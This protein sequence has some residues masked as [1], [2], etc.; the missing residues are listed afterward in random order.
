V[1]N[2][3]LS[4][5][6]PKTK[7]KSLSQKTSF[8]DLAGKACTASSMGYNAVRRS[9]AN[10]NIQMT[11]KCQIPMFKSETGKVKLVLRIYLGLVLSLTIVAEISE[12]V[13]ATPTS[14]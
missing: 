14:M 9:A 3:R 4:Q 10:S 8:S 1:Q 6:K 13:S 12:A 11:N 7:P 2:L 5:T